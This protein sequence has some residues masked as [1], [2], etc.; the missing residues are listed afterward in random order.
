MF[1]F[2]NYKIY[3]FR[4]YRPW[5]VMTL[6]SVGLVF[7]WLRINNANMEEAGKRTRILTVYFRM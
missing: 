1:D 7:T 4:F 5:S 6:T 3:L 2:K